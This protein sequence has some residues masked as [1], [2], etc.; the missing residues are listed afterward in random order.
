MQAP[1]GSR[2]QRQAC[3]A[4]AG[5]RNA[6][7]S[8]AYACSGGGVACR[9]AKAVELVQKNRISFDLFCVGVGSVV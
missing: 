5:Q 7:Q 6:E 9:L 4:G 8:D 3:Q 1:R 2:A